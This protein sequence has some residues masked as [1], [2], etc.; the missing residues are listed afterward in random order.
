MKYYP[1][2]DRILKAKDDQ[3]R[4]LAEL[5]FEKQIQLVFKLAER[6]KFVESGRDAEKQAPHIDRGN[7]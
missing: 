1:N 3:R 6:R 5:S 4:A 2:I 7:E